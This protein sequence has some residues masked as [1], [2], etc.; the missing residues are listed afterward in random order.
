MARRMPISFERWITETTSTAAIPKATE[1][2]TNS[3]INVLEVSAPHRGEKLRVGLD[4]AVGL[5][6]VGGL[7]ML[8]DLLGGVD[9]LTVISIVVTPPT[10]PSSECAV[11]NAT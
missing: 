7:D 4:P 8:G 2:P 9:V 3:R 6:G 10:M 1:R 5:D 11:R